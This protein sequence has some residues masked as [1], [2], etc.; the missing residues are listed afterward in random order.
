MID[1]C[2]A[3]LLFIR[4]EQDVLYYHRLRNTIDERTDAEDGDLQMQCCACNKP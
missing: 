2:F 3:N 4:R 1:A